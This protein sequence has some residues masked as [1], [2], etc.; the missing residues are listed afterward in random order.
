MIHPGV[1]SLSKKDVA[2][3]L[4]KRFKT[5]EGNVVPYGL[6]CTFGGDRSTGFALV[7]DN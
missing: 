4:A 1:A 2:A 7:Y 5:D 6:K 3:L